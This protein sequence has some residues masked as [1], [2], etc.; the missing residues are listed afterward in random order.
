MTSKILHSS[1]KGIKLNKY[2]CLAMVTG[3][4]SFNLLDNPQFGI[5]VETLSGN[6]YNLPGRTYM[7]TCVLPGIHQKCKEGVK[8]L[9]KNK[10]YIS[11]T[12]DAWRSFNRDSYITITAHVIDDNLELHCK[13]LKS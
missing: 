4:V 9:L 12:T 6:Q 1:L 11:F 13:R 10:K 2:L 3:S 5:F 8:A 7:S